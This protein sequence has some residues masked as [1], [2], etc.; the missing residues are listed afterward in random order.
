MPPS[1]KLLDERVASREDRF[2]RG[3]ADASGDR[4][5]KDVRTFGDPGFASVLVRPLVDA[6]PEI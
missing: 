1:T 4:D 5:G 2:R 6:E 3:D